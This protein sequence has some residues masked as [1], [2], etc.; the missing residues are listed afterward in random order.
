MIKKKKVIMGN[1]LWDSVVGRGLKFLIH[2]IMLGKCNGADS[3]AL[4]HLVQL[5]KLANIS[6]IRLLCCNQTTASHSHDFCCGFQES[7]RTNKKVMLIN[8]LV[9]NS[10]S[11]LLGF[12]VSNKYVHII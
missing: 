4:Q 12:I 2:L 8:A 9:E 10:S 7:K 6:R 11:S 3:L 5:K 1:Q